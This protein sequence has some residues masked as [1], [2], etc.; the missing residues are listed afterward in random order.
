MVSVSASRLEYGLKVRS[1]EEPTV[2]LPERASPP[3]RFDCSSGL[4][5]PSPCPTPRTG[6]RLLDLLRTAGL[7]R[8]C[9][10]PCTPRPGER[11]CDLRS[12]F[13]RFRRL[14]CSSSRDFFGGGLGV[15][16]LFVETVETEAD[17]TERERESGR[18]VLRPLSPFL[19][20][21]SSAMPFLRCTSASE[22]GLRSILAR[23]YF[24]MRSVG[25]SLVRLGAS[26]G[27]RSC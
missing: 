1:A 5:T 2:L 16:D 9:R 26:S 6:D 17:D 8:L 18:S 20:S 22:Q 25:A 19:A 21:S 7:L 11:D 27:F 23:A 24:R 14:D 3:P 13:R 10:R 4:R 15:F 12:R